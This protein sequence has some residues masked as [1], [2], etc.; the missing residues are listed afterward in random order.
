MRKGIIFFI[1]T[2]TLIISSFSAFA[3]VE[4]TDEF[5]TNVVKGLNIMV[6]DSYGNMN[7][8]KSLTRAEFAKIA[9]NTSQYRDSVAFGAKI[10]VFRDCTYTHWAAP[11]VKVAVTNKIVTGYPD[12][13]FC[14]ENTVTLEEAVTVMLR[15]IGYTDEDFGNTWPYGQMSIGSKIGLTEN[16]SAGI[17]D[18]LTRSDALKLV[19]NT[20]NAKKKGSDKEY[21]YDIDAVLYDNVIIIAT[22]KEDTSV[23]PGYVMT[24]AGTFKCSYDYIAP[25]VGMK[26]SLAT[27]SNGEV[28]TFSPIHNT[29]REYVV[30]SVLSDSILAY[31]NGNLTEL[32]LSSNT[33]V[34][35]GTDKL[36][37]SGAKTSVETGDVIY[38]VMT[39]DGAVDYLTLTK[40]SMEGPFTVSTASE[41]YRN[42]TSDASTISVI[43]NG[44]RTDAS[45]VKGNDIVYYSAK[46]NTAFVYSKKATGVY[47]E[48]LPNKETPTSVI[49]SGKEYK[50][51]SAAAF[52]KLSSAGNIKYGT[53]VTLLLG[54]NSEIADVI[55]AEGNTSSSDIVGYL[56]SSGSK[57]YEENG[58][59][60]TSKYISVVLTDGT[61]NEYKTL[62]DYSSFVNSV[63][64]LS[65]E[66]TNAVI[67]VIKATPLTGTVNVAQAKIGKEKMAQ[68]IRIIDVST[69]RND[70][71]GNAIGIFPERIDGISL[72]N[73]SV[74]WYGKNSAG[75]IN[76][77]ILHDVTG[78]TSAYGIITSLSEN[79]NG[80]SSVSGNYS[81]DCGTK[82]LRYSGGLFANMTSSTPVKAVV[83]NN[84]VQTI[85][86]LKK[87]KGIVSELTT[88]SITADGTRYLLSDGVVI[89]KKN[90][91]KDYSV[92]TLSELSENYEEYSISAYYDKN[93]NI[94]G[95]I[96][97]LLV[98]QK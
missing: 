9:V 31:Q 76:E 43:R 83:A 96:R 39:A 47:E 93:E 85:S 10:S 86:A 97:V 4:Y 63:V 92:M 15:L 95:R 73:S 16:I 3:A 48:A 53:T 75:E 2:A 29:T 20:L 33:P 5:A 40:D 64:R 41:W 78:D 35:S 90:N 7:L 98:N 72:S 59:S 57:A 58:E 62:K 60:Y 55:T 65:F 46:L 36:T 68:D 30:Y 82:Q 56:S 74:L 8:D 27:K 80:M 49:I 94:G 66:N 69:T 32:K 44:E 28:F 70:Y 24:S 51:E 61:V 84:E 67:S 89:F 12:G 81:I 77:L 1:L 21:Y 11:Y 13:T 38:A 25:F 14:P 54:K 34:Y 18:S 19:Y 91:I 50:I 22:N 52:E 17:G 6:G 87:L 71:T 37:F 79:T 26:G 42:F 23:S 45:S 88:S